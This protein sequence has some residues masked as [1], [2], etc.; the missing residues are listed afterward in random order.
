MV[1]LSISTEYGDNTLWTAY[2]GLV[3]NT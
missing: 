1:F 3:A 2:D